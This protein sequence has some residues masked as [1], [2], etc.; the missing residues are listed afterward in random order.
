MIISKIRE[1]KLEAKKRGISLKKTY[2][3]VKGEPPVKGFGA[4][5]DKV[6]SV[7]Q[8]ILAFNQK[9]HFLPDMPRPN[10]KTMRVE[11]LK[12]G[13]DEYFEH[14][15]LNGIDVPRPTAKEKAVL[16]KQ[17][18]DRKRRLRNER[19]RLAEIQGTEND[20]PALDGEIDVDKKDI[21][22][23]CDDI[24]N[25][26]ITLKMNFSDPYMVSEKG[27][28]PDILRVAFT[29]R[30]FF[31]STVKN[32]PL[33]N[34][35]SMSSG[36]P[37]QFANPA[38]KEQTESA[39]KTAKDVVTAGLGVSIILQIFLQKV[40]KRVWPL[41]NALQLLFLFLV[42]D[43]ALP[44]NVAM[45]LRELKSALELGLG[46]AVPIEIDASGLEIP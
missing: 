29:K 18:T 44:G 14:Q 42:Y 38:E 26:N 46:D 13:T 41:Y 19:R 3:A 31:L 23:G 25:S 34:N 11:Y 9:I 40:I 4:D 36:M 39:A 35:L 21:P 20:T 30:Y 15:R 37:K 27:S 22:W 5:I 6:S 24:T 1:S 16:D 33:P 45:C 32:Q 12:Y 43:L 7:G 28:Y 8:V 17:I 10:R 2:K